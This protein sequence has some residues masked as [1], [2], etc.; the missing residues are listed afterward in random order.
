MTPQRQ[1]NQEI[2]QGMQRQYYPKIKVNMHNTS[3]HLI[4]VDNIE[5]FDVVVERGNTKHHTMG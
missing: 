3:V 2:E 1:I 4:S 5:Y